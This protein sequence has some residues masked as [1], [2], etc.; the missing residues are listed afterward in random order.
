[1]LDHLGLPTAFDLEPG[2][3]KDTDLNASNGAVT[4]VKP[5]SKSVTPTVVVMSPDVAATLPPDD[6]ENEEPQVDATSSSEAAA[7]AS[8][9]EPATSVASND[10]ANDV[11]AATTDSS[12]PVSKN[13][14]TQ[15]LNLHRRYRRG[16]PFVEPRSQAEALALIEE[17]DP[18]EKW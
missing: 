4:V 2:Q 7:V 14:R 16:Q 17:L 6:D 18:T 11:T 12:D 10:V 15:L 8:E 9:P 1:M 13:T 5:A 3:W